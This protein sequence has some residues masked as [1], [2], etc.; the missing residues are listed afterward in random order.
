MRMIRRRVVH[1][2][3]GVRGVRGVVIGLVA[4]LAPGA[5]AGAQ[6]VLL[7]PEQAIHEIFPEAARTTREA[8][9]LAPAVRRELEHRL[10]RRID[11]DSVEVTRVFDA[12]DALRGY[13]VVTEEIGKYRPITFMVGV[14]PDLA[15]RD[16]AVLV[17]RESR[18]G[19][20]KRKRFLSQYRGKKAKDPIDVNR[21]IINVSGAT[22]SVRSLNAGV[23]R[24][25]AE[26][27]A[28]YGP[29]QAR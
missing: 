29:G 28:L 8:R 22:I 3:S 9:P 24:V 27:T 6:E 13:A 12:R 5:R 16:V 25:L 17:Y 2:T 4:V 7:T 11:E 20:V 18:G 19:E 26:L 21:D 10:G 14:T 1:G 15:V 23:K